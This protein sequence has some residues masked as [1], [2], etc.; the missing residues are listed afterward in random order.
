MLTRQ[1]LITIKNMLLYFFIFKVQILL[2]NYCKKIFILNLSIF[3]IVQKLKIK[4]TELIQTH[5]KT[6]NSDIIIL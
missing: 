6:I 3:F 4:L 2:K 5:L 1:H